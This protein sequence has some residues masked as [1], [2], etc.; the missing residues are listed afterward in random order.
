MKRNYRRI[1]IVG[2]GGSGKSTLSRKLADITGLP[3]IHL[4]M[5]FWLPDWRQMPKDEWVANIEMMTQGESWIIDGN[6]GGTMETRFA[7]ADLVI[8]LDINRCLC[9]FRVLK[10]R[11]KNRPDFPDFLE[12]KL[13]WE[14]LKW[15]GNF[16]KK[17]KGT[18]LRLHEKYP[19]ITF[20]TIKNKKELGQFLGELRPQASVCV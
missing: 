12:E 18:I 5:T 10:R 13:D 16:P 19:D 6:Y 7:A 15:I 2:S 8:F 1:A 4:D 14:F 20:V 11:N 17:G 3:T 9:L